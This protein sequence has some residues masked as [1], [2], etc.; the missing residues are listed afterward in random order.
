MRD[1]TMLVWLTQFGISVV[2]PIA[3]AVLAAVWLQQRFD[4]SGWVI[5][6]GAV[7]GLICA[8]DGLR[9]S[10]KAMSVMAGNKEKKDPPPVSFNE[11][12]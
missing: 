8:V 9:T 1:L 4:W 3:C 6:A 7:L 10:L 5:V 11:H 12:D 2:A